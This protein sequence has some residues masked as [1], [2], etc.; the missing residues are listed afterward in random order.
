MCRATALE[1]RACAHPVLEFASLML[2][3]S[4]LLSVVPEHGLIT[5]DHRKV[6][7]TS[8]AGTPKTRDY[9]YGIDSTPRTSEL[10][11]ET[12][13]TIGA[14]MHKA[15]RYTLDAFKAAPGEVPDVSTL[16]VAYAVSE[17]WKATSTFDGAALAHWTDATGKRYEVP[18]ADTG[19]A[20]SNK[21][22]CAFVV[23]RL[24]RFLWR[25]AG[26]AAELDQEAVLAL[27]ADL[28]KTF[29]RDATE[30]EFIY[31]AGVW[32]QVRGCRQ[33]LRP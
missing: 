27:A 10:F 30:Q 3:P 13:R 20:L 28:I 31:S 4:V 29:P 11:R 2:N 18:I 8:R 33:G 14:G 9:G 7:E 6:T 15:L 32:V 22:A 23:G 25:H 12:M 17:A 19:D 24:A 16:G 21:H 1:T 5:V 26:D